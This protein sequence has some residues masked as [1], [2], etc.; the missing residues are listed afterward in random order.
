MPRAGADARVVVVR[1][2]L[3]V[4]SPVQ[5]R[6]A[7][8]YDPD[9]EFVTFHLILEGGLAL[10]VVALLARVTRA[11]PFD[12]PDERRRGSLLSLALIAAVTSC[13][14]ALC[15]DVA[16]K[17]RAAE[18]LLPKP[19]HP[20]G[21]HYEWAHDDDYLR[22]LLGALQTGREPSA[23]ELAAERRRVEARNDLHR[24]VE[25]ALVAHALVPLGLAWAL[26]LLV[27]RGVPVTVRIGAAA[28]LAPLVGCG[29]VL[30]TL[31]CYGALMGD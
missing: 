12:R 9:V 23:E 1:A 18:G 8:G 7:R 2:A 25:R 22:V 27:T 21:W 20:R 5:R 3:D 26:A 30:R 24:A 11:F 19:R 31:D 15:A 29:Y 4:A 28:L 14:L 6:W 10:S 16:R 17:N 13:S